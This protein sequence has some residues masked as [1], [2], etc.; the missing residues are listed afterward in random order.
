MHCDVINDHCTYESSQR[1]F[2]AVA[3]L[4]IAVGYCTGTTALWNYAAEFDEP[5]AALDHRFQPKRHSGSVT[6]TVH[7][8]RWEA[9]NLVCQAANA[10]APSS[11][12]ETLADWG[13]PRPAALGLATEAKSPAPAPVGGERPRAAARPGG[14]VVTVPRWASAAG[15]LR[16]KLASGDAQERGG[17]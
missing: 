13:S 15:A 1:G 5:E 7:G 12:C 11:C 2:G 9:A 8:R 6:A 10:A 17:D 14:R 16:F 3:L 4:V